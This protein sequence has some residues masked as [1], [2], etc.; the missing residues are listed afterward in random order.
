MWE[1]FCRY[2]EVGLSILMVW[3]SAIVSASLARAKDCFIRARPWRM[4]LPEFIIVL[5]WS[6]VLFQFV[7]LHAGVPGGWGYSSVVEDLLGVCDGLGSI[8]NMGEEKQGGGREDR[9]MG[10][11][12]DILTSNSWKLS[13]V[14]I[15]EFKL[16]LL[17]L[18]SVFGEPLKMVVKMPKCSSSEL[19]ASGGGGEGHSLL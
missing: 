7:L 15:Q 13:S 17:C 18:N 1:L 9:E 14:V 6:L 4:P 5:S 16:L 8:Y 2:S 12:M 11:R 19:M 10:R 3:F